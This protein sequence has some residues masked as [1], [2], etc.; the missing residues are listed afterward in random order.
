MSLPLSS[1]SATLSPRRAWLVTAAA[2]ALAGCATWSTGSPLKASVV[3]LT[4][5]PGE[6]IELRFMVKL[7]LQNAS[8]A[9]IDFDGV[10][11]E[12]DLRGM[13]FASGVSPQQGTVPR[14]G[15]LLLSVPVS[16]P[17]V[18]L[19][20]QALSLSRESNAPRLRIAYAARG[21]LGGGFLGGQR[22]ESA[23]E[24]DWPPAP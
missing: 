11:L 24:I 12:L 15:E 18:A 21:R 14:F 20:R 3:G 9:A 2:A 6:G 8:D 7:R 1:S 5:L 4:A 16:I 19:L 13:S 22:F 23:G 17:A 10:S